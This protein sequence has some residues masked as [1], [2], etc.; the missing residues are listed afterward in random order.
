MIQIIVINVRNFNDCLVLRTIFELNLYFLFKIE[1]PQHNKHRR[2]SC[3][4][5][6]QAGFRD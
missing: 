4:L 1:T 2:G 6:A 3:N 5:E